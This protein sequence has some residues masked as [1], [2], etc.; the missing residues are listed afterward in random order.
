MFGFGRLRPPLKL[1]RPLGGLASALPIHATG[2]PSFT[3]THTHTH[4]HTYTQATA[5]G[6]E[7]TEETSHVHGS[8]VP[9]EMF[10]H[11]KV[12]VYVYVC[13]CARAHGCVHICLNTYNTCQHTH[14][15]RHTV[16]HTRKRIK[17]L[18]RYNVQREA[19]PFPMCV[20]V[21]VCVRACVRACVLACVCLCLCEFVC[22]CVCD[23]NLKHPRR[24]EAGVCVAA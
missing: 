2:P 19:L 4:T 15:N 22:E 20:C 10:K 1:D 11:L 8:A 12:C 21:C 3:H 23:S 17:H 5:Y 14:A 9:D 24:D 16:S 6:Q 7:I 18:Q 13:V